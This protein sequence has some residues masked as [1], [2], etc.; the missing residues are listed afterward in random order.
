MAANAN[1]LSTLQII[2]SRPSDWRPWIQMIRTASKQ[3][4]IW[5]FVNPETDKDMLPICTE[6]EE[7][8][9]QTINPNAS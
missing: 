5:Q 9:V 7:P 4:D 8:T 2:L 1:P 3:A 6:P